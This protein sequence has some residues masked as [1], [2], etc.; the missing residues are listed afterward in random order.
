MRNTRLCLSLNEQF[1][2]PLEDQIRLFRQIGFEGFFS[3]WKPGLDMAALRRTADAEGMLYQS[4]HGPFHKSRSMWYPSDETEAARSELIH[5]LRDCADNAVP[6]MVTHAFITFG[7]NEPNEF[8]LRNFETV[9]REAERL[10]VKIAFENAE[11]AEYLIAVLNHFKGSSSV[12]F[13]WDTGHQMCYNFDT[14]LMALLG[15]RLIATHINDNLGCKDFAGNPSPRDDLHLLPFDGIGDWP[16]ITRKIK[17]S[18]FTGPLTFELKIVSQPGRHENDAY[19][20]MD[21][22]DYLTAAY[23]RACRVGALF[24]RA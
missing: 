16:D 18:G 22:T 23:A 2:I 8:G 24:Q 20:R 17:Q 3:P 15:D 19:A 12:G 7:L 13:C 21:L 11:G 6:I 10:G 4:V 5:C 1:K 14:D 9:V